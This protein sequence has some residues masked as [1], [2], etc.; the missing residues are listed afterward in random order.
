MDFWKNKRVLVTG[1]GGFLGSCV[2]ALLRQKNLREIRIPRSQ[3]FD[4]RKKENCAKVVKNIDIVIHL[5]AVVGGI[6]FNN[7]F[8]GRMFYDN[9]L[10]GVYMLDEAKKVGVSKFVALGTVCSYPKN[11]TIPFKEEDLWKGYP[12]ETNAPYGIA[13]KALLVQAYAYRKQYGF[14]SI[15]LIPINLYG[16]RDKADINN[17]HVVPTL[18][19][20]FIEAKEL[21]KDCVTLWGTGKPSR[22]FLYVEDAA[23]GILL[24]TERYNKPDPINLGSDLEITI[25][26]LAQKIKEIV[27]FK[28]KI[29]WDKTKPDGQ[30]RRKLNTYKALTEFG[31]KAKMAFDEGLRKTVRW[32]K[33]Y[34]FN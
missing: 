11:T 30:P 5:A 8:P 25:S 33:N 3:E 16:P 15:Y 12:E 31:F 9:I 14:N 6:G 27:G 17:S 1:G 4:L 19:R 26:D 28:G 23:K 34:L 7:E 22:G 2:V 18:I 32:Y 21:G 20:K 10:M 24:A 13:K 29:I